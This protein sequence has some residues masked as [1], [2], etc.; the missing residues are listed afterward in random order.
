MQVVTHR[1]QWL[2][3]ALLMYASLMLAWIQC[4]RDNKDGYS[5]RRRWSHSGAGTSIL[6]ITGKVGRLFQ[7]QP[8]VTHTWSTLNA[9]MTTQTWP[10]LSLFTLV[11]YFICRYAGSTIYSSTC[12][13]LSDHRH[14]EKKEKR[15]KGGGGE[16]WN[17]IS[18]SL[19]NKG[20]YLVD[21]AEES[22]ATPYF[23]PY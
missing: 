22:S 11:T 10:R 5:Q 8:N 14:A 23:S 15:R 21:L 4:P 12:N 2:A 19:P 3:V 6:D 18:W 7:F 16:Q 20:R 9:P 17:D 1:K 13:T